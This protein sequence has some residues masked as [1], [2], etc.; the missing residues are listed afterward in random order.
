MIQLN[1]FPYQFYLSIQTLVYDTSILNSSPLHLLR[2]GTFTCHI[3]TLPI[4]HPGNILWH[5]LTSQL[6]FL[7]DKSLRDKDFLPCSYL[8]YLRFIDIF[9]E[10]QPIHENSKPNKKRCIHYILLWFQNFSMVC[11]AYSF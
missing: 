7:E 9:L 11:L 2:I 3:T 4:S 5:F 1:I 8:I 6:L 10:N